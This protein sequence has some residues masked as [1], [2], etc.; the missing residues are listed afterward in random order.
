M[1]LSRDIE[2]CG[3]CRAAAAPPAQRETGVDGGG[4]GETLVLFARLAPP[5]A[6]VEYA[7]ETSA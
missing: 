6:R 7:K 2:V 3:S 4:G 5:S 1:D